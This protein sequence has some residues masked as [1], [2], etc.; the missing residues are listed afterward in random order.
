[1][2]AKRPT[3]KDTLLSKVTV[4]GTH[5]DC[6]KGKLSKTLAVFN[7]ELKNIFLPAMED[8][9]IVYRSQ[10]EIIFPMNLLHPNDDDE[11]I[12]ELIRQK[13]ISEGKEEKA[14]IPLSFFMFEQDAIL[15]SKQKKG[16]DRHIMV[17]SFE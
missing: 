8:E 1:M 9:L 15:Y 14:E 12:L 6:V 7:K 17:L 13:I 3:C 11:K 5:R 10:D 2:L 4:I 16:K